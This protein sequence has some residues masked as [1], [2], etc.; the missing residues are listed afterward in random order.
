MFSRQSSAVSKLGSFSHNDLEA[1]PEN[2]MAALDKRASIQND[3][4]RQHYISECPTVATEFPDF[5]ENLIPTP[6][7]GGWGW[8]IVAA[9]FMCNLIVDGICYSFGIWLVEFIDYFKE[10]SG[11]TSMVGSLCAGFY[12]IMGRLYKSHSSRNAT[13][14]QRI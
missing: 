9:S 14:S 8:I 2:Q 11:K 4:K 7:D 12:L 3:R 13:C 1:I 5:E 6:P 10:G